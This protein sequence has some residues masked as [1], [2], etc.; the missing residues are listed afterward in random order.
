MNI[1]KAL[2][3]DCD[4]FL[5]I[6]SYEMASR[7]D[8]KDKDELSLWFK[9]NLESHCVIEENGERAGIFRTEP[10]ISIAIA[11]KPEFRRKK[12]ATEAIDGIIDFYDEKVVAFID[13][14]NKPSVNMV[15]KIGFKKEI[16]DCYSSN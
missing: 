12:L 3:S 5:E 11:I 2:E 1:R 14:R 4:F 13:R 10:V 6:Q 7:F 16:F 9:E 15:K 8:T